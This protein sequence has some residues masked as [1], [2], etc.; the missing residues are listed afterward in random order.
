MKPFRFWVQTALPLVYDDSL[1]YYELLCKVI[2]YINN[3]IKQEQEFGETIEHYTQ[4][5][6]EMKEFVDNYFTSADFQQL[7]N[8]A[9]DQMAEDGEFDDV[10][11]SILDQYKQELDAEVQEL[12][13][14]VDAMGTVVNGYDDRIQQVEDTVHGYDGT[15]QG[16]SDTVGSLD[17]DVTALEGRVDV[18][19]GDIDNIEQAIADLA[20]QIDS[21]G[22]AGTW[23]MVAVSG[24]W[25]EVVGSETLTVRLGNCVYLCKGED[26]ILFD[27]GRQTSAG[28]LMASLIAHGVKNIKGI[29]ISHWHNDHI[30]GLDSLLNN[31]VSESNPNGFNFEGCKFFRPHHNINWN[32]MVGR[33]VDYESIQNASTALAVSVGC[34]VIDPAENDTDEIDNVKLLFNNL[35]AIKF[36]TYYSAYRNENLVDTGATQY[37]NFSMVCSVFIGNNK[38]VF[39]ADLQYE[40]QIQ[41]RDV[42]SGC[43]VYVVEH[44]GL[45]LKTDFNYLGGICANISVLCAYGQYHDL[46]MRAKYPTINKCSG[47][48]ELITTRDSDVE[49]E[50]SPYG[51][52]CKSEDAT[53]SANNYHGT[54]S[55]GTQ[56]IQGADFNDI[57]DL[58]IYTVQNNT[59]L[60]TMANRPPAANAG[61]KLLVMTVTSSG[62]VNQFY[63]SGNKTS[64]DIFCRCFA[65]GE[66]GGWKAWKTL[67]PSYDQFVTLTAENM[68]QGLSLES[69]S[70]SYYNRAW[71]QNGVLNVNMGIVIPANTS[72][73]ATYIFEIPLG[74]PA[75]Y[76]T[77]FM[78]VDDSGNVISGMACSYANGKFMGWPNNAIPSSTSARTFRLNFSTNIY[79]G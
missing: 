23:T 14:K 48:G 67:R 43:S 53:A 71:V 26:A 72:V 47:I 27:C 37:N 44:H 12:S 79:T 28:F 62:A 10:I 35:D 19:D 51:V 8:D 34:T 3:F 58:G 4:V 31:H 17:T 9:I 52:S 24:N 20:E 15:I 49:I 45:N 39:P 78:M 41:N 21:S 56:L 70:G 38:I 54:L 5:V 63:L 65:V 32:S 57:V 2:D 74:L 40:G 64:P 25:T 42:V 50:I 46:A 59:Q 30:N 69:V 75:G 55:V 60:V 16:I 61:G 22:S 77:N 36:S 73:N 76:W 18:I 68:L 11:S 6:I 7:V 29:V 33:T 1:S 13:D 66:N